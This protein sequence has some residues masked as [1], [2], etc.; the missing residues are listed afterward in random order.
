MNNIVFAYNE[1]KCMAKMIEKRKQRNALEAARIQRTSE[2]TG[3]SVRMVQM[4]VKGDR[5]N[6][7][8]F[9]TYMTLYEGENELVKA[10]KELIPFN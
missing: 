2:I 8:V 1:L 5:K 3:V 9:T 4:V 7:E 6:E 10:V